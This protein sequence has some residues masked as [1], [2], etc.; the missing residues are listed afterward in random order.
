MMRPIAAILASALL[1]G[2]A[3]DTAHTPVPR[4]TAFPRITL[5]DTIYAAADSLPLYLE[6][7]SALKPDVT[8]RRDGSVWLT[9]RY[10]AYNATLYITL[11]PVTERDVESVVDNRTER[12]HLNINGSGI[13]IE[14]AD[15]ASGYHSNIVRT[16]SPS[17][18]PLQF[19]AVNPATPRWVVYG[20][21]FFDGAPSTASLDS[22][23]PVYDAVAVDLRHAMLTLSDI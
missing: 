14:E 10:P 19:L 23:M 11:S 5:Y 12:M 18:T 17:S 9:A 15:N 16:L 2:C 1:V 8:A 3:S 22:L 21:V 4:R 7:N 6:L 20:S 13:S